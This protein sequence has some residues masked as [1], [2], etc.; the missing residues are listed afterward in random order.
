MRKPF[1]WGVSAVILTG[2]ALSFVFFM[3][4]VTVTA[5]EIALVDQGWRASFS[6]PIKKEAIGTSALVVKDLK[7]KEVDAKITLSN[8][9]LTVHVKGLVPGEYQLHVK[10][11]A[12][13]RK[14]LHELPLQAIRFQVQETVEPV[15]SEKELTAYFERV[16]SQQ[17]QLQKGTAY[18]TN[19]SAREDQSSADISEDATANHS[20]TNNQVEGVDEADIVKTDGSFIYAAMGD[21]TVTITDIRDP[22]E[23]KRTSTIKM[24]EKFIPTQ[25]FLHKGL[26][27]VIGDR[28]EPYE[29]VTT[30]DQLRI[31]PVSGMTVVQMYDIANPEKPT[32]VREVGAE[33]YLSGT[34]KTGEMLYFV[35]TVQPPIWMMEKIEGEALRPRIYDSNAKETTE[36][37]DYED[38]AV[39]PG[40]ME[41]TYSIITAVDLTSPAE[42]KVVTKGY[43]G[44]SGQLYM[45]K[46]NLYLTATIYDDSPSPAKS[47]AEIMIWNPGIMNSEIFKFSLHKT[48]VVF[49]NS[50]LLRGHVLNQFSMDEYNGNF[51]VVTTEGNMW[52]EKNP[53]KNHLFIL[54]EKMTVVGSIE[55]LAKGE[56][57]YSA[58]FMGDKAYMVT[59]RETDPLFVIDVAKPTAP[60]VLGELKIPGFSNYLHP[61]DEN[62]LIGFGYETTAE[63]VIGS[64]E[65]RILT[66]GMKISL[67]DVTDFAN[68]KEKDTE[69]IGGRGTYSPIQYD[70]KALLRHQERHLFGFPAVVYDEVKK[71]Q[72]DLQSTGSLVYEITS[73]NGII[74]KGDLLTA[75]KNGQQYEEWEKE[76][77]RLLYSK[78]TLFTVSMHEVKSYDLNTFDSIGSVTLN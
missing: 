16:L 10:K 28:Y 44:G 34:R 46:D 74:L 15:S 65:P 23:M 64:N 21:G 8:D 13:S 50:A 33:G 52:D 47:D 63:K 58:R 40:A 70:H 69:I 2:I 45:S 37:M 54:N 67:F 41:L 39:L 42:S 5:S 51:R 31:M 22:Q 77:R 61:L 57:I 55:G 14:S 30:E 75:K 9:N 4:K 26:L 71:D 7:G 27:V 48:E 68:P 6:S 1:I 20:T 62:H 12:L 59:F 56:R 60:K 24:D 11:N 53:S 19:E 49:Q 76:I 25:L 38:I 17:K 72:L 32:F 35:T 43:L 78:D 66:Q 3:E 73:E 18:S 29:N 36:W